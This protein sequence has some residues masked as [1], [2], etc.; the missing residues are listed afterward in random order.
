M[1]KASQVLMQNTLKCIQGQQVF[2]RM[3]SFSGTLP[4]R[5]EAMKVGSRT[6][7]AK[8][9]SRTVTERTHDLCDIKT[10]DLHDIDRPT[11]QTMIWPI[12]IG[13]KLNQAPE[14]N[15][16]MICTTLIGQ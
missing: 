5:Q 16:P 3:P 13:T 8:C 10:H 14:P 4:E 11:N 9:K 12:K 6:P 7:S 15:Q 2:G 1:Q